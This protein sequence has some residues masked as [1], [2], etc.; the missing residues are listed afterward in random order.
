MLISCLDQNYSATSVVIRNSLSQ[1]KSAL[2]IPYASIHGQHAANDHLYLEPESKYS[3]RMYCLGFNEPSPPD[4]STSNEDERMMTS[5]A[6]FRR[7]HS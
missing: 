5:S 6:L 1:I 3:H 2:P 7:A 4:A